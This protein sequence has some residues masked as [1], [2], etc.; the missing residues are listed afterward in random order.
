MIHRPTSKQIEVFLKQLKDEAIVDVDFRFTDPRGV[1]HHMTFHVDGITQEIFD[2]GIAFDGSSIPG[3]KPIEDS[4]M[5]MI[6][7]L[8]RVVNDPFTKNPTVIVFCD[9]L[10]PETQRGYDRDPRTVARKAEAYLVESGIG[11]EAYFGP[12]P[13]FFVFDRVNY[14]VNENYAFYNLHSEE[15]ASPTSPFLVIKDFWM[16]A[17]DTGL[18][19]A[20]A[21]RLLLPLIASGICALICFLSSKNLVWA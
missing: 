8:S 4:D 9:I 15:C 10:D 6:P 7:D 2:H 16:T 21:T 11:T 12:E 19:K 3:W 1:W 13:E 18:I 20:L 5:A 14:D 17:S